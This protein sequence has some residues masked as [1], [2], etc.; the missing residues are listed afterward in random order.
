MTDV[1]H[2]SDTGLQAEGSLPFSEK[3][4]PH[5]SQVAARRNGALRPAETNFHKHCCHSWAPSDLFNCGN[6][7]SGTVVPAVLLHRGMTRRG[8]GSPTGS[9]EGNGQGKGMFKDEG[10]GESS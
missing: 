3:P 1:K 7:G 5:A 9:R 6:A 10:V 4:G 2:P 8:V